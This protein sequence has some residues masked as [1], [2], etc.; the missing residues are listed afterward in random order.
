MLQDLPLDFALAQHHDQHLKDL[1]K[2]EK[3]KNV[4]KIT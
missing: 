1:Q 4:Q 3:I 2:L